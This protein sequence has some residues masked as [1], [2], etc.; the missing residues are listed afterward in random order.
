MSKYDFILFVMLILLTGILLV[1]VGHTINSG[2][3]AR[4]EFH[5]K[6]YGGVDSYNTFGVNTAVCNNGV[7]V[8]VGILAP[9][10]KVKTK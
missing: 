10:Y 5:C 1:P 4:A 2:A 7:T 9:S 6:N 8:H 3:I